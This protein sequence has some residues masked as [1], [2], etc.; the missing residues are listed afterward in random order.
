MQGRTFDGG[1]FLHS[2]FYNALTSGILNVPQPNV[3]PGSDAHSLHAS[4]RLCNT[5]NL[6]KHMLERYPKG[7]KKSV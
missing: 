5:A 3:L 2:A 4:S 6:S 7:A 1:V